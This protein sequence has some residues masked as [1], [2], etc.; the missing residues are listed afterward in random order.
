VFRF[1]R[2][3][4]VKN[5][6]I[7]K[8]IVYF[9][10]ALLC[11]SGCAATDKKLS[12]DAL[13]PVTSITAAHVKSPPLLKETIGST[14]AGVTGMMFGAIGGGLGGALQHN[15]M[16]SNGKEL[17][18]KCNLPNFSERLFKQF[19]ERIGKEVAGWPQIIVKN[20]PISDE[21]EVT[22][23]YAIIL[24][25]KTVKVKDDVGLSAW[26]TAVLRDPQGNILWEKNV[27]Y[28]TKKAGR[29][30]DLDV[31]EADSGKLLHQEY[32]FAVADTVS[33]LIKDLNGDPPKI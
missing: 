28:E 4:K 19:M 23:D 18:E 11:F 33:T 6:G 3:N 21:S 12:R 16:E 17:H 29:E 10:V 30:C 13:K 31:L 9:S 20:E 24:K 7:F 5:S 32:D 8:S 14:V 25:V 26:T 22:N 2:R 27:R 1:K 15:L